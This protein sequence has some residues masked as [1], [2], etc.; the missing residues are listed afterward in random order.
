MEP[1]D[2]KFRN[3]IPTWELFLNLG[4]QQ[5]FPNIIII[6]E[7]FSAANEMIYSVQY[8]IEGHYY[9]CGSQNFEF[10]DNNIKK[11]VLKDCDYSTK[12]VI[13]EEIQKQSKGIKDTFN[14]T[15]LSIWKTRILTILCNV[16]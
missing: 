12:E 1:I 10:D 2:I 14:D 6:M 11:T 3:N 8:K 5:A 13:S 16:S 9:C 4:V 7:V 15:V